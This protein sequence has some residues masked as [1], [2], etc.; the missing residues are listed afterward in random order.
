[1]IY[2]WVSG[3][4]AS[5]LNAQRIGDALET[6]SEKHGGILSQQIV[7][8]EA[9][10]KRSPLHSYFEWD[11]AAAARSYRL[12]QA[13]RILR[14]VVI[15][16]GQNDEKKSIRAFVNVVVEAERIFMGT[17]AAM[18]DNA[19]REQIVKRALQEAERWRQRY[20][21]YVELA[22]I[23]AAIDVTAKKVA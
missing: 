7:L 22:S 17:Y 18:G 6:L 4:H 13:S 12:V 23:F 21:E 9:R 3:F 1:M 11:D 15:V 2:E 10:K 8:K 19:I 14:A 5:G 20:E 16:Y